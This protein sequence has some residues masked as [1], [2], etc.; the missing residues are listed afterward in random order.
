MKFSSVYT[1]VCFK[2]SKIPPPAATHDAFRLWTAPVVTVRIP[3]GYRSCS[4][5]NDARFT[6]GRLRQ[7]KNTHISVTVENRT[8]TNSNFFYNKNLKK[9][10]PALTFT[11]RPTPQAGGPSLV[12]CPR[13]HIQFIH[14]YPPYRRPFLHPQPEDGPCRG[15]RDP[16]SWI[17][18]ILLSGN[19]VGLL[20]PGFLTYLPAQL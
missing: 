3:A 12:G 19:R 17:Y 6:E 14:S 4:V 18:K 10:F 13:L 7:L 16:H 2:F 5:T 8:P 1:D 9:Q 11:S 20:L 15:D